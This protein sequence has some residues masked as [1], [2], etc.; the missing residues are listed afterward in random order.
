MSARFGKSVLNAHRVVGFLYIAELAFSIGIK[1]LEHYDHFPTSGKVTDEFIEQI[2]DLYANYLIDRPDGNM[3]HCI[4]L[5]MVERC[6]D[7]ITGNIEQYKL[8]M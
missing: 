7:I 8:M 2:Q 5:D 3:R 6:R 1:Y 4:T